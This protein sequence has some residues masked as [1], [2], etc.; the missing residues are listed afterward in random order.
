MLRKHGADINALDHVGNSAPEAALNAKR[1][2]VFKYL[3]ANGY[4]LKNDGSLLRKA[5]HD[6]NF[7]AVDILVS[8]GIDVNF[9]LP[10]MVFPYNSTPVMVAAD[11]NDVEMVKRLVKHGADVTIRN[12]Y[13]DRPYT[14]AFQNKNS[15]LMKYIE[16]LE[17]KVLHDKVIWE[18]ELANKYY[19]P[20]DLIALLK[21]DNRRIPMHDN[22]YIEYV[23]FN[24]LL[25]VKEVQWK[26]Y[27]FLDL[28]AD[29]DEYNNGGFLVW[30]PEKK[31]IASADYEHEE[32]KVL[33][34]WDDF[35]QNP[36]PLIDKIW[37]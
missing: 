17:P 31:C 28:I 18:K 33:G 26:G 24:P 27:K 25:L 29:A 15:E 2:D 21:S 23:E 20:E 22:E 9:C 7:E 34:T 13:G 36:S 19:V 1:I 4:I 11:N 14:S 16:S 12:A 35:K 3:L 37:E 6:K 30:L 32:L 5:V 8:K 10:D